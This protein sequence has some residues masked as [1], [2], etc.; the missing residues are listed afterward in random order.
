MYCGTCGQ[1][2]LGGNDS[3]GAIMLHC[4]RHGLMGHDTPFGLR[5]NVVGFWKGW[6]YRLRS[7]KSKPPGLAAATKTLP[8]PVEA[9]TQ[10]EKGG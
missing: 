8:K 5:G 3:G 7:R 4:Q 2:L 1:P 6:W 9:D 10:Q